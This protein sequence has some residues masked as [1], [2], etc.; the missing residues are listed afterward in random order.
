[1]E[2]IIFNVV[3]EISLSSGEENYEEVMK[4]REKLMP[5]IT[6]YIED[7]FLDEIEEYYTDNLTPG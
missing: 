6:K 2:R 1:M 7:N 5:V 3:R 4:M